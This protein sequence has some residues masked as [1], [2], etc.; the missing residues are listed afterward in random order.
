[1]RRVLRWA[2]LVRTTTQSPIASIIPSLSCLRVDC[3]SSPASSYSFINCVLAS[4]LSYKPLL[5]AQSRM[6]SKISILLFNSGSLCIA[7][8]E[9]SESALLYI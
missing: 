6:S 2:R 3:A 1:M 7:N 9:A 4:P 8:G 5:Y